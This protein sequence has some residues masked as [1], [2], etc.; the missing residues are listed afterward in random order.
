MARISELTIE[1]GFCATRFRSNAFAESGPLESALASGHSVRCIKCGK[2]ILCNTRN[3]T[4]SVEE[5]GPGAGIEF[6]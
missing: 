6:N 5:T 4:W 1:C 2:T 3:T